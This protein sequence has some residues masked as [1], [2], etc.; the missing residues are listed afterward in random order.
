MFL[1]SA[2]MDTSLAPEWVA[3]VAKYNPFEWAVV[4]GRGALQASP[5]WAVVWTNLGLLAVLV[6]VMTFLATRAFRTYQ[7]SV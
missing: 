7:R 5:D 4:A 6:V 2:I 3:N 1:S